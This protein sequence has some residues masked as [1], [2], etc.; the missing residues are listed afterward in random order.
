[1]PSA[2]FSFFDYTAKYTPGATDEITPARISPEATKAVQR[3]AVEAHRLLGCR[4]FSRSDF[5][6]SED[7]QAHILETNTIPGLTATSLLPQGAAAIGIDYAQLIAIM[8]ANARGR[9][10]KT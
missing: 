6:L 10:P 2:K 1:V 8:V 4:D 3:M 7:G 9:R 5:M